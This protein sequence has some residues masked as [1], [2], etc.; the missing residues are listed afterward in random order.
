MSPPVSPETKGHILAL[1]AQ[2]FS[3]SMIIKELGR[4]NIRVS[5]GTVSRL[6]KNHN[7]GAENQGTNK[8]GERKQRRPTICTPQIVKKVK[9]FIK[10]DNPPTQMEMGRRVG[11]SAASINH[12]IHKVLGQQK[13]MK[14]KVHHLT[15]RMIAQRKER[16]LNFFNLINNENFKDILTMDEAMLPLNY[17]NGKTD[18]FYESKHPKERRKVKPLA[19][20]AP[21]HPQQRMFAAGYGWRGQTRLFIVPA[22]AKVN[23]DIFIKHILE[24]MMLVDV[25][26]I[27]GKDKDR[28]ILHM[29]SARAHTAQ[30]VYNWLD[31]HKIKYFTKEEWL[32]N[33][34][35]VSPMDFFAN[36]YFKGQMNKRRYLTMKG[37]LKA[38]HEE[39]AKI[40]L[41]MF[42]NSFKSW[43][44][45]VLAI[46]KNK[47]KHAPIY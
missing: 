26:R 6:L 14:P 16:A 35:E 34:P 47:G 13:T 5:K 23:A 19:S 18:F 43:P 24:P 27:Y 3:Q 9:E 45:R 44:S 8:P 28:V 15:D 4:Q 40:P 38:A 20:K 37:M 36:G 29:D 46:H 7:N 11:A 31:H 39:W 12:L 25:P 22:K 32:A 33:S 42:Q 30:K 2:K 1:S 17:M 10:S 21:S 41:E